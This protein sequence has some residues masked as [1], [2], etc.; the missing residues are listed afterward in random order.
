MRAINS[1][2]WPAL[3]FMGSIA[4]FTALAYGVL[5]YTP[6]EKALAA[7]TAHATAFLLGTLGHPV[8][9][10]FLE[11]PHLRSAG[12]DAELVALCWGTLELSLWAGVV[13]ATDNRSWHR[14]LKGFFVG[15]AVFL[16]FNP[17]RIA[18]TLW[19]FDA[20]QRFA[21]AVAHDVLFR[22][23]LVALFVV[24]Y[25]VWYAWPEK[26]PKPASDVV[27]TG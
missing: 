20:S 16:L 9:V 1:V 2:V 21:S 6:L 25:S 13:L 3:K 24:C 18:L 17:V 19:L 26:R 12:F 11:N 23:S 10:A 8:S 27:R 7:W 14:R 5:V 22:L 15:T 4:L